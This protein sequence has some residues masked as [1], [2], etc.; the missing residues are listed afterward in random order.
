[1]SPSYRTQK[2]HHRYALRAFT[3]VAVAII[4]YTVASYIGSVQALN[5]QHAINQEY[6]K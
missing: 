1:M 5:Y 2:S 6:T 3:I 4:A